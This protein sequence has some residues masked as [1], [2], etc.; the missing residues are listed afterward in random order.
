[1]PSLMMSRPDGDVECSAA[2]ERADQ[3]QAD[4]FCRLLAQRRRH[5]DHRIGEYQ[6]AIASAEAA[7]DAEGASVLRRMARIEEQDRQTLDG[8]I[9]N[10]HRRF[11]VRAP[12][13]VPR[14]PR[15][16]RTAVQ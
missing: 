4:Y 7:G 16:A 8:L 14:G 11:P 3:L 15:R 6:K 1:M 10:L 5:I 2:A 13:G 12:G 9:E